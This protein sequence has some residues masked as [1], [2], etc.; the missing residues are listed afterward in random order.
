MVCI[1]TLVFAR[2]GHHRGSP[3]SEGRTAHATGLLSDHRHHVVCPHLLRK[4][5]DRHLHAAHDTFHGICSSP[6]AFKI[7]KPS[8]DAHGRI[9]TH[10]R[11]D[12]HLAASGGSRPHGLYAHARPAH[13]LCGSRHP[14]GGQYDNAHHVVEVVPTPFVPP[15]GELHGR[16]ALPGRLHRRMC[17]RRPQCPYRLWS[18]LRESLRA[19]G[20]AWHRRHTGVGHFPAREHGRLPAPPL[21]GNR[22]RLAPGVRERRAVP[23]PAAQGQGPAPA[24]PSTSRRG[25]QQHHHYPSIRKQEKVSHNHEEQNRHVRFHHHRTCL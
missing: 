10:I 18:P 9:D 21:Q 23:A 7:R 19:V 15:V 6:F 11:V 25:F 3:A 5:E 14:V 12:A 4:F 24:P 20:R 1:G 13:A 8:S 2:G 17:G 22:G 16:H